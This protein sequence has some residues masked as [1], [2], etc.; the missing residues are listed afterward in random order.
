MN[1]RPIA[2]AAMAAVFVAGCSSDGDQK[3]ARL[4]AE[5]AALK[6]QITSTTVA[7]TT[8]TA[9]P[10]TTTVPP[11]T[12]TT[13]KRVVATTPTTRLAVAAVTPPP[14]PTCSVRALASPIFHNMTQTLYVTSN[15]PGLV[16]D[17]NMKQVAMDGSGAGKTTVLVPGGSTPRTAKVTVN[18]YTEPWTLNDIVDPPFPPVLTSCTTTYLVAG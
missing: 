2:L 6:D 10:T 11:T 3:T 18:F 13:L 14:A 4:E 17:V 1:L 15:L 12:T 9:A 5:V 8:T 16:A 7:P